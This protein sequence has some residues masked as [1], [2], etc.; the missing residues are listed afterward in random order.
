MKCK[1]NFHYHEGESVEGGKV[2]FKID[3]KLNIT[4]FVRILFKG[5]ASQQR[6][7][8]SK[9]RIDQEQI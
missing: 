8:E 4:N 7:L 6:A 5:R 9:I 3:P 1:N 2:Y